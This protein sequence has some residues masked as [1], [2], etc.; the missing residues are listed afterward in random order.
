MDL[1]ATFISSAAKPTEE[2]TSI[3]LPD[4][5]AMENSPLDE[6]VTAT[7]VPLTDTVAKSIGALSFELTT[8]PVTVFC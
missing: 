8:L 4:G 7:L 5:T 6:V 3:F 1:V 2:I